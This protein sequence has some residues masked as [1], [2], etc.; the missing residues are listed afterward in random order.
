M[1]DLNEK[2]LLFDQ[3]IKLLHDLK[4]AIEKVTQELQLQSKLIYRI[5]QSLKKKN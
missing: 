5:E 2:P 3:N 4:I 1:P